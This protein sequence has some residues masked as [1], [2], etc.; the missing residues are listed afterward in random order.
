[1]N[2]EYRSLAGADGD[3]GVNAGVM[4]MLMLVLLPPLVWC[5]PW[6]HCCLCRCADGIR[7]GTVGVAW[8]LLG[9]VVVEAAV[10]LV[11]ECF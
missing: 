11:V 1:V 7:I 10:A 2:V 8:V 9:A 4:W 5:W 6:Q 3:A